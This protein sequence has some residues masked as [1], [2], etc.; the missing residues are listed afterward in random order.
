MEIDESK[1]KKTKEDAERYYKNVQSISC[2]Y[3]GCKV[4]FNAK[5]LEHI[6]FKGRRKARSQKDQYIR[7][8]LISLAPKIIESSHTLQGISE[9]KHFEYKKVNSRWENILQDVVYYEFI[10]VVKRVRI[11]IIVKQ[12][13][14]G[15]KHFW[16]II[17]FWKDKNNKRILHSGNP[18]VD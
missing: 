15:Q 7:L 12:V 6:K 9:T 8:R 5:G 17:P 3:F 14:N 11:R 2:P 1:F 4:I 10:A 16:S 18:E 13:E